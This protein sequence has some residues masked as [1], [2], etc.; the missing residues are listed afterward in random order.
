M[1]TLGHI[2]VRTIDSSHID[3]FTPQHTT[4]EQSAA[5]LSVVLEFLPGLIKFAIL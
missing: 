4:F 5:C 3:H 2:V 1:D